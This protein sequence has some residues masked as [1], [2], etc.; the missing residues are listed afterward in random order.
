[1]TTT[2]TTVMIIIVI[3]ISFGYFLFQYYSLKKKKKTYRLL[4]L[5]FTY[6]SSFCLI[7]KHGDICIQV[8]L[9]CMKK[10]ILYLARFFFRDSLMRWTFFPFLLCPILI[11]TISIH[12][13]NERKEKRG[14]WKRKRANGS[15]TKNYT[16]MHISVYFCNSERWK[17]WPDSC[18]LD[19][20]P[21]SRSLFHTFLNDE[22][23][24]EGKFIIVLFNLITSIF[25]SNRVTRQ[26][27]GVF[28]FFFIIFIIAFI[29][30]REKEMKRFFLFNKIS[31]I[32]NKRK[33][34]KWTVK[35]LVSQHS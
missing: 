16:Y 15:T 19:A 35:W 29:L 13:K 20:C 14:E 34:I 8:Q 25:T 5:S 33:R 3:E 11:H 6:N 27:K 9:L 26:K 10:S 31:D 1:M 18:S 28:F 22:K 23:R 30:F 7:L 24:A 32:R 17:E 12:K 2:T 21:M 4:M